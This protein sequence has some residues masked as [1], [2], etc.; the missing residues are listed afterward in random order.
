VWRR[1]RAGVSCAR[2]FGG[3][4]R[5]GVRGDHREREESGERELADRVRAAC[6]LQSVEVFG[7]VWRRDVRAC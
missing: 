7:R 1:E 6:G 5:R 3:R 2:G 4:V